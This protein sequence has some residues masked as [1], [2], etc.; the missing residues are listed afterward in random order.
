ML[1]PHLKGRVAFGT[2]VNQTALSASYVKTKF[3]F[4][5]AATDH[6]EILAS[7]EPAAVLIAT[8]NHLHAP[9]VKAA[10]LAHRH[11]FVEK[12][13][14]LRRAELAVID[15]A[16]LESRGSLQV[17][18][19]RRF[20]PASIALK[21]RL[22]ASPGPKAAT[23][24]VLPGRLDPEHWSAN[25]AESGG[26]VVGEV[27]HFLDYFCFLF[28]TEP[29][30]L[31]AQPLAPLDGRCPF[32]DSIAVQVEFADG[33]CGQLVYSAE[34]DPGVPKESVTVV[35][36][37]LVAELTNV[38]RLVIHSARRRAKLSHSSKGHAEQ[39]AAWAAFLNGQAAHP[40]PY[41]QAR[42]SMLLTFATLDSIQERRAVHLCQSRDTAIQGALSTCGRLPGRPNE[43]PVESDAG[44]VDR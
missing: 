42:T 22:A 16:L 21:R 38:Q 26:R 11:V 40:F 36:S 43:Q 1:L 17:G 19:N 30:R 33:S 41:E 7:G 34:G 25:H 28:D 8:R 6:A 24:R 12:P 4:R 10:L 39:M 31:D 32:P 35:G 9:L 27:C 3:G 15:T 2:V 20:A 23:Y 29:V 37:G 18:F 44:G 5:R 13:L 14:C